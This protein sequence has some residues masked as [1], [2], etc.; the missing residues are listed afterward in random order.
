MTSRTRTLEP[1]ASFDSR[2]LQRRKVE[3]NQLLLSILYL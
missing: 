2:P 1:Q 3:R